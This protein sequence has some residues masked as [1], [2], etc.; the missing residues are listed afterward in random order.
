MVS[1]GQSAGLKN[2]T[3]YLDINQD[4]AVQLLPFDDLVRIAIAYSPLL[5]YQTE[6]SHSLNSVYEISKKQILQNA[7]AFGNYSAGNQSILSTGGS[8]TSR[9]PIGQIA[10]GYRFG[11]DVR[12]SLFDLFGRKHQIEQAYSNYR[13]SVIQKDVVE[14][15]LRRELIMLYQDMIT[16]QQVLKV[17]LMDDQASLT[18]L[19]IA[20][21][22]VQKGQAT[23]EV[24]ANATNR[25]AQAKAISEQ[26]K[27]EFLK[28]VHFFET[29]M[30]VPIQ[31]LKRN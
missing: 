9:D 12:V 1:F 27:G 15:Q 20:E 25:Y 21:N 7:S 8:L 30:G 19:R 23:A 3:L 28:N 4:I 31:R 14:L 16:A 22:D 6:I 5:K 17:R 29:I 18:A 26:V 10:N 24:L 2:D 11:V 13:A